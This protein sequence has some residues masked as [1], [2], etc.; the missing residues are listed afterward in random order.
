MPELPEVEIVRRGLAKQIIFKKIDKLIIK[1]PKLVKQSIEI[2]RSEL[3]G[4]EIVK[5]GR[6]GKLLIFSLS[7]GIGLESIPENKKTSFSKKEKYLLIHLKMTGQLVYCDQ[8]EF[9]VGGH[10]NSKKEEEEFLLLKSSTKNHNCQPGKY[11]HIIFYF[12]DGSRLFFNDLRQFGMLKVVNGAE[13]KEIKKGYG[14]EP[15]Q[16][17]FTFENFKKALT[18]QRVGIKVLLLN[19]SVI[20]GLG[21]I[22]VDESLFFAGIHPERKV[23]SL[24]LS[25]QEKL[26]LAI[27]KVIKKAIENKGTTFS[28]FVDSRGRR[29]G[30]KKML[31]VY[32]RGGKKCFF[33]GGVIRKI[34]VGGRG[35]VFC[36]NCQR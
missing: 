16:K 12:T 17:N 9:L 23:D 29:G 11:T 20:A 10:I 13:L 5:V 21:N 30:F 22:Y 7:K 4:K 3:I 14:I 26:F 15:G 8:K 25:E 36:E 28:N 32:G 35:T 31:R 33:C 34:K 27:K 19:Q 6:I 1:K 2:F 18:G 24:D